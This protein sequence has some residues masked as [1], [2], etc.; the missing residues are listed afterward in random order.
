MPMDKLIKI[1][2]LLDGKGCVL[3]RNEGLIDWYVHCWLEQGGYKDVFNMYVSNIDDAL[4]EIIEKLG[5][6]Y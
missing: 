2:A 5:G 4:D 6:N 3:V 1:R